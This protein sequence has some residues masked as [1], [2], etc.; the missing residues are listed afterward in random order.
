MIASSDR[1]SVNESRRR[2]C[3]DPF[4]Q[5][6]GAEIDQEAAEHEFRHVA[7][8]GRS[9]RQHQQRDRGGGEPGQPAGAAALKLR[10]V[11]LIEMQ[12]V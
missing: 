7:E 6:V 3:D 11:R 8:H 2:D 10:M 5:Q 9:R 4:V 12:P 1:Y